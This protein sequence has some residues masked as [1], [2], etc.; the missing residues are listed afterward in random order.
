M[1]ILPSFFK[2]LKREG[3]CGLES[4]QILLSTIRVMLSY[5]ITR[6]MFLKD[7]ILDFFLIILLHGMLFLKENKEWMVK[8]EEE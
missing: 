4:I 2:H 1:T 6:F 8:T 3:L 5:M 7:N